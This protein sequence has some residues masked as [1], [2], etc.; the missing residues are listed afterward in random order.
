MED[1]RGVRLAMPVQQ[2]PHAEDQEH[3][4]FLVA[5][6]E[7]RCVAEGRPGVHHY[8]VRERICAL[9]YD[10][11]AGASHGY[12]VR[13]VIDTDSRTEF[14]VVRRSRTNAPPFAGFGTWLW[15]DRKLR[16]AMAPPLAGR[17]MA[18]PLR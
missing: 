2:I 10:G 18:Q 3:L 5:A 16:A 9:T 11:Q 13:P 4:P 1:L 17:L 7:P 12:V 14:G 15:P 8:A 6:A